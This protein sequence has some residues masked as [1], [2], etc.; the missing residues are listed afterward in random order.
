MI[1]ARLLLAR[2][3][4]RGTLDGRLARAASSLW[5]R[6]ANPVRPLELPRARVI[7]VGGATLGGSYKTPVVAELARQLAAG[8]VAVVATGYRTNLRSAR[9]VTP[10][11]PASLVGDEAALLARALASHGVA[12]VVGPDRAE[13]VALAARLAPQVLVDGLLQS[14]PIRLDLS[15]LVVDAAEPWGSDACPPSGDRRARRETLLS[16]CDLVLCVQGPTRPSAELETGGV[17]V[18]RAS[19]EISGALDPEGRHV[20]VRELASLSLGA[21]LAIARPTRLLR[22]LELLGVRPSPVRL[23]ADH[24]RPAPS[25][26]PARVDAWLTTAKCATK[27]GPKFEGSPLWT[28]CHRVQ[29]PAAVLAV[30]S[31]QKPVIE[32][33]PCSRSHS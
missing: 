15:I 33:A 12:V 21:V 1:D 9:R 2:A 22:D 5:E 11:D 31:G 26:R 13:A 20:P 8:S 17:P 7:G 6:L 28:L 4:E 30:A 18:L 27:L 19:S 29:L 25:R 3:L 14:R 32:S 23:A 16:A 24:T 10:S